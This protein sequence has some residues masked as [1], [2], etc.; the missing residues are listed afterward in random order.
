MNMRA[1]DNCTIF[2]SAQPPAPFET[3]VRV[4]LDAVVVVDMDGHITYVN[5]AFVR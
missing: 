5:P 2:Q 1:T 4:S 3:A